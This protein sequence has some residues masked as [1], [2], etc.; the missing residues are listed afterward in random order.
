MT[1]KHTVRNFVGGAS[2]DATDGRRADLVDPTTGE[3]FGSAPVSGPEDVDRAFGAAAT[4]LR[5]AGGTP[6]RRSGSGR[7]CGSPTRS[8]STPTSWSRWRAATPASRSGLTASEEI[9]PMVDQ[10]RFFAGAAR[11]AR[12]QGGGRVHGGSHVVHPARADR[13]H[14]TGDAVE[15][16][17]DDGGLEVRA[18]DRRRQH[19]RPQAQRHHPGDDR[20]DGRA[21]R[22]VPAAGRVQRRLRRPRHRPGAGRAP[23][24]ADGVDHGLGAAPACRSPRRRR[25]DLKRVHLELGG[26]APVV[27]FDDADLEAA[28]EG[29]SVAG[30]FNAGQDCTAATRVLAAPGHLRRLRRRAHRAGPQ[31]D[32]DVRERRRGRGRPGARRQQRQPAGAGR[33]VPRPACP[34]TPRSPRAGTGRATAGSSSSRR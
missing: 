1:D 11:H 25:E 4:R 5:D 27:V 32:H 2:V 33:R 28:A 34:T 17:D 21:G 3:V 14:R 31:H 22:R 6:R 29:I 24:P 8:R 7:C 18:R 26:K 15:L 23:H 16:P 9:P 30:Y 20:A 19:R 13:R 10:I 12:G